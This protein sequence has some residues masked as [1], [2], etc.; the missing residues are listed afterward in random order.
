M[1]SNFHEAEL[2][3]LQAEIQKLEATAQE[4][5]RRNVAL[6]VFLLRLTDPE[7]LGW[8][9]SSEVCKLA[10]EHAAKTN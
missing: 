8:S 10:L 3:K 4:L 1:D 7:D 5:A 9:V 2:Q 6:R